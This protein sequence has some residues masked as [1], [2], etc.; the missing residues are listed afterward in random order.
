MTL[1]MKDQRREAL[2][3]AASQQLAVNPNAT[4]QEIADYA[5]ISKATLHRYFSGRDDLIIA[6]AHRAVALVSSAINASALEQGDLEAA[7]ARL[8]E[9]LIPLGDKVYFLLSQPAL[10]NVPT[11]NTGASV[12]DA[13][14]HRFVEARQSS[15]ELRQDLPPVWVVHA[16][17]Y[18]MFAAW[19]AVY[20]GHI[21]P[22]DAAR[23]VT[24][25]LLHGIRA[26]APHDP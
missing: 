25:T 23:L 11:M 10:E 4:L 19:E 8:L 13:Q 21:A 3:D 7:L 26:P 18:L 24:T 22:R 16:L 5:K 15:N 20:R 12:A 14:L 2:L 17:N 9:T 1:P 6:L